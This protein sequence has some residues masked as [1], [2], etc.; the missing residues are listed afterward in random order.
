[1][2]LWIYPPGVSYQSWVTT[3]EL[4]RHCLPKIGVA[5]YL[6]RPLRQPSIERPL[7]VPLGLGF[8]MV[9]TTQLYSVALFLC[10]SARVVLVFPTGL[11]EPLTQPILLWRGTCSAAGE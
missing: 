3:T 10:H 5:T 8:P 9:E 7:L 11:Q 6:F 4:C 2:P 1:M